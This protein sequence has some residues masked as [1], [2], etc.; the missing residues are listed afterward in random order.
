[1][2]NITKLI[3]FI[4]TFILAL[5]SVDALT[6]VFSGP[7]DI[8][9]DFSCSPS[10]QAMTELTTKIT[11][12]YKYTPKNVG[13][14]TWRSADTYSITVKSTDLKD[15]HDCSANGKNAIL[16]S[17]DKS[18]Y[19]LYPYKIKSYTCMDLPS[20]NT[21]KNKETVKVPF[22]G[23]AKC[24]AN[25]A[26]VAFKTIKSDY[27][28]KFPRLTSITCAN[29]DSNPV[30]TT[31]QCSDGIDND[32]DNQID[33][34]SDNG[35]TSSSDNDET[36]FAC[37]NGKA[38]I[39]LFSD[40]SMIVNAGPAVA[41]YNA[42]PRWTANIPGA[43]WVWKELFVSDPLADSYATFTRTF[44]L[45]SDINGI[46]A[47]ITIAADNSY[48][49]SL[50]NNQ[51]AND[52]LEF[53][54]FDQNK[55]SYNINSLVQGGQN[56][57]S[58]EVKN[59]ALAKSTALTNPAGLLYKL[60][61]TGNSAACNPVCGNNVIER[62]E[63]CD[64]GNT[65]NGDGCSS[66]CTITVQCSDTV[67]NDN[68]NQI[69]FPADIGC[70]NPNDSTEDPNPVCGNNVIER[71]EQ[72]DD[73]NVVSGD[74]CSA[75]CRITP[76]K[77]GNGIPETG[78]QC[79]DGNRVNG[80]GCS[81]SC[82]TE[83]PPVTTC[84]NAIL[85]R[86]EACDD[87]NLVNGDGCSQFCDVTKQCSDGIDNDGDGKTDFPADLGCTDPND[88]TEQPDP[89][90][91]N[92]VLE[93]GEQC[94]DG[95]LIN[96]DGCSSLC[97]ITP[98]F[99]PLCGN[100]VVNQGETCDDGNRVNGDGCSVSCQT[101]QTPITVCG[102][103]ILERN[104]A[105]DDGNLIN[106]D[107]C[108]QFCD[109]TFQ[110]SDLVDND[111][112]GKIDFPNDLGCTGP[113]DNTESPD[114]QSVCGNGAIEQGETCDDGNLINGDGCSSTCQIET[115]QAVCGNNIL[116]TP[117]QCDDGNLINGDGCSSACL[118]TVQCSDGVDNDGDTKIDFPN[119][120]GCSSS[121]DNSEAPDPVCPAQQCPPNFTCNTNNQCVPNAI[122][123][124]I[125]IE[126]GEQC[127][128]G[129]TLN[130]DGCS[131]T[132]QNEIPAGI[133]GN[134]ITQGNEQC[135]DGNTLD[136]DACTASCQ[137]P[138]KCNNGIDDDNDGK[139]DY[140]SDRGC[141]S[142]NDDD[143]KDDLADG[144]VKGKRS[145]K[146]VNKPQPLTGVVFENMDLNKNSYSCGEDIEMDAK[147]L[148]RGNTFADN[149]Y[150]Q[151]TNNILGISGKTDYAKI[152]EGQTKLLEKRIS[153]PEDADDGEYRIIATLYNNGIG[154]DTAA[155]SFNLKDCS[156]Y[157]SFAITEVTAMP[158]YE[159]V[160]SETA[161]ISWLTIMIA[162]LVV[163]LAIAYLVMLIL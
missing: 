141:S 158:A 111:A 152:N 150:V 105:C 80:D 128:D 55:D 97:R 30:P 41:T 122:C 3:L 88:N 78:E 84:G 22:D 50:N 153:L 144:H 151:F 109:V 21:V 9:N 11:S 92:A 131:S 47:P 40:S 99:P 85:E 73:G 89:I 90:C 118:T 142:L 137:L 2:R 143:E 98:P 126:I 49:C 108:S 10:T 27:T 103:S 52:P 110:C 139:S 157:A 129:N 123:G 75:L 156:K 13:C 25:K 26:I 106:G 63:Q 72:C 114:P 8:Q 91:G 19:Y 81:I 124:N 155:A 68:D 117:E 56:T 161:E 119:D 159:P 95:N 93:R 116:E 51:F 112:D 14:R 44:N 31:T 79:D 120:P 16:T 71:G 146:S 60:E 45:P 32:N 35:C 87:G 38:K 96:G 57:L 125:I 67:N 4:V 140:P 59:W 132:C 1:M 58:C 149:I 121:T 163:I 76:S 104:E 5:Q 136:H 18:N 53:N 37:V 62:G 39:T 48:K 7:T 83:I 77:C 24:P 101:E 36:T 17:I 23:T 162:L 29:I 12:G 147:L 148:N 65:L 102:N 6:V 134:G 43:I 127:D 94:D 145:K 100:G 133:C 70:D 33:F 46:T 115:A 61:I 66:I 74:G 54:Y 154:M 138:K 15:V 28:G 82:Q 20:G 107:G 113:N 160:K 130:G 42:N 86:Y 64:D 135:D 34:P 69:D